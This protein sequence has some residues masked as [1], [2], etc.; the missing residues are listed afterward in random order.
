MIMPKAAERSKTMMT[1]ESLADQVAR[2]D[3]I[4]DIILDNK[5]SELILYRMLKSFI[6]KKGREV[7]LVGSC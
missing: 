1:N 2:L 5:E 6:K 3:R 4:L 7:I